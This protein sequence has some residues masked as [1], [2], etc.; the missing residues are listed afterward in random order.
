MP[1]SGWPRNSRMLPARWPDPLRLADQPRVSGLRP[2]NTF[3]RSLDD[4]ERDPIAR[5]AKESAGLGFLARIPR[6]SSGAQRLLRMRPLPRRSQSREIFSFVAIVSRKSV[7][8]V[9]PLS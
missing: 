8:G 3:R 5:S 2:H 7:C 1:R 6:L 9:V 4:L